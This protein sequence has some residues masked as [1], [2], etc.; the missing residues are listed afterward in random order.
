[1]NKLTRC[2]RSVAFAVTVSLFALETLAAVG[3]EFLKNGGF[4]SVGESIDNGVY[5]PADWAGKVYTCSPGSAFKPNDGCTDFVQGSYCGY[6]SNN[7]SAEQEFDV[8][9]SCYATLT[10]KCKHRTGDPEQKKYSIYYTVFLDDKVIWP[11][12]EVLVSSVV[13]YRRIDNIR[14]TPGKHKFKIQCRINGSNKST[15]F[16]D[17][18][19]LRNMGNTVTELLVNGGFEVSTNRTGQTTYGY[20]CQGWTGCIVGMSGSAYGP[21]HAPNI[22]NYKFITESWCGIIQRNSA[23]TQVFTNK[24]TCIATLSW[25]CRRRTNN[26]TTTPMHYTVMLDGNAIDSEQTIIAGDGAKIFEKSIEAIKLRP[27]EHTLVFQGRTDAN[28]DE[29]LFLDDVSLKV[30]RVLPAFSLVVR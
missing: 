15:A 5:K 28:A 16:F 3:E 7:W 2:Y 23:A 18:I 17:D 21:N 1:M 24:Y 6:L 25:R 27:G 19:S 12:E 9:S 4:E 22:P 14:L 20:P 30:D 29:S 8:T 10:W 11:E 26:G 13:M